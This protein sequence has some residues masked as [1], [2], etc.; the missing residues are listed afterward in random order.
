LTL[1]SGSRDDGK[2]LALYSRDGVVTGASGLSQP[3]A[4]MLSRTAVAEN[5]SLER[6]HHRHPGRPR[7]R[8]SRRSG[9]VRRT[10]SIELSQASRR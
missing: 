4:L 2:W 9:I 7:T 3:R 10:R 8:R 5:W 6:A 1:S